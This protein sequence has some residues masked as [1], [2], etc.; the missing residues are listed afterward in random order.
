MKRSDAG[1]AAIVLV[2]G[3]VMATAGHMLWFPRQSDGSWG[4]ERI[5]GLG[6]SVAGMVVVAAW[7]FTLV[8]ALVAASL[9]QR[10]QHTAARI[11]AHFTPAV[12]RRLAAAL[13][14]LNLLAAPAVAQAAPPGAGVAP[15]SAIVDPEA[16]SDGVITPSLS[17]W[18]GPVDPST[19]A[20]VPASGSPYW[21]GRQDGT[22][23]TQNPAQDA[24]PSGVSPAW[25]P[26]AL[27]A[28]GG[29]L[30]RAESRTDAEPAE[31][32]VAPGDSLWSIVARH[33]GPLATAADVAG[34]WPAWFEANRSTIGDDPSLLIPGQVLRAPTGG[35]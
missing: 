11:T 17:G 2:S 26:T 23:S 31:I 35:G 7:L 19:D 25:K 34:A 14:G 20:A 18:S 8:V 3:V 4:L 9:E 30:V 32:A 22:D 27:P 12:M 13:L 5:L 16:A 15:A 1:Q 6:V 29:L 10:G 21:S 24:V 33:L 28:D